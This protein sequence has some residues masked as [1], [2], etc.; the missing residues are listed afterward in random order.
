VLPESGEAEHRGTAPYGI[1]VEFPIDLKL[2]SACK[3]ISVRS[4]RERQGSF[5]GRMP[6]LPAAA[7]LRFQFSYSVRR[8]R[9]LH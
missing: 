7:L 9:V 5:A 3:I 6:F 4:S 8:L 2:T 1:K